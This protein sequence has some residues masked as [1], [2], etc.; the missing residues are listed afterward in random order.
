MKKDIQTWLRT[1]LKFELDEKK[2]KI[3][4]LE[5][6]KALFLGFSIFRLKKRIIRKSNSKGLSFRQRSTVPLTI[7]IDHERVRSRLI[8]GKIMNEQLK[9]RSN[10]LYIQMHPVDMVTKYK[11]RVE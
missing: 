3:T 9:P 5:T 4:N 1:H 7:G 6:D 10:P 2:T 11:Q 8:A